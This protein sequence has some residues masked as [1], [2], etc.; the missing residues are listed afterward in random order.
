MD[1]KLTKIEKDKIFEEKFAHQLNALYKFS[2]H[3]TYNQEDAEDLVQKTIVKVYHFIDSYKKGINAKVWLFK[4]LKNTFLNE[5][6]K[7][8]K[9][10]YNIDLDDVSNYGNLDCI[11][12][13]D[14]REDIFQNMSEEQITTGLTHK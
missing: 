14:W 10:P 8:S 11:Q 6:L 5:Y 12:Y 13:F 4:I 9:R 2:Y 7:K 1:E 3:L